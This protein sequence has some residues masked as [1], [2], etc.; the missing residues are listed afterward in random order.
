MF[1]AQDVFYLNA[2]EFS[3]LWEV[4]LLPKPKLSKA[5]VAASSCFDG[6]REGSSATSPAIPTAD[7][8][9]GHR[10]S[11]EAPPLTRWKVHPQGDSAGEFELNPKA[12]KYYGPKSGVL[13]YPV[14]AG[15]SQDLR[16]TFYLRRRHRPMVPAPSN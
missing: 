6:P 11:T 13:F 8:V 12:E 14:D 3:M 10:Q 4:R 5:Q 1:L 2:W 7:V 9:S 15:G 16:S